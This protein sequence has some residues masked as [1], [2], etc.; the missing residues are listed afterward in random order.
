[1][2]IAQ[3]DIE[4]LKGYD[5]ARAYCETAL[6]Q[7]VRKGRV[8]VFPC[9]FGAH[10]RP[11]LELADLGGVG[12]TL[13]RACN[14][15]GTV[16]DVAAA[17]LGVDVR[18]HFA[19]CVREV[20][21]RVGYILHESP[22]GKVVRRRRGQHL[23]RPLCPAAPK[24]AEPQEL[25]PQE[26]AEALHA[27]ARARRNPQAMRAHAEALGLPLEDMMPLTDPTAAGSPGLLGLDAARRLLYIYTRRAADGVHVLMVKTRSTPAEVAR[28]KPRFLCRG[29]KCALFGAQAARGAGDVY[30][31]EGESDALAVRAAFRQWLDYMAHNAPDIYPAVGELPTVLAKPDAG[32]FRAEWAAP[33]VAA[34]VTLISDADAAG[35]EG[36]RRTAAVLAA[37]GVRHLYRW[38]PS[39]GA[40]DARAALRAGCPMQL[41]EDIL[42]NRKK[43]HP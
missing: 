22:D 41:A 8:P 15:G 23:P 43:I 18:R 2:S 28:G 34:N 29:R 5:I 6:G 38:T 17:V 1:M 16:L 11:H 39:R 10:T 32:T 24:P 30:I 14:R 21:A 37:A 35:L 36:A 13:C 31:T 19:A 25:P 3:N 7:P 26:Q 27:V 9:P 40:K 20:A 33:L 42:T 12:I 4:A